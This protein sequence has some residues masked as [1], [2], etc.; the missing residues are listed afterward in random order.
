MEDKANRVRVPEK[1]KKVFWFE[2]WFFLLFGRF[3]MHR[4]W[5]LVDRDGYAAF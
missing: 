4:V 2:L 1:R 3:H 5:A